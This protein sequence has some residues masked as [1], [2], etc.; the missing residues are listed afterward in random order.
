[1]C[2]LLLLTSKNNAAAAASVAPTEWANLPLLLLAATLREQ[3]QQE[4]WATIKN[5]SKCE[6]A[7]AKARA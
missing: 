7:L 2:P 3:R 5:A 6:A 4:A 1:L